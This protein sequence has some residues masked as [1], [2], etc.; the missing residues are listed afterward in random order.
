MNNIGFY[1]HDIDD[2]GTFS[3]LLQTTGLWT[4]FFSVMKI[5]CVNT[6]Y[7]IK[8]VN[9]KGYFLRTIFD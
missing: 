3:S 5:F 7:C 2:I 4:Q 1:A 9:R 8:E 6:V